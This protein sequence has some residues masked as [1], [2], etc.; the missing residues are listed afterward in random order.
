MLGGS[1]RGII[2]YNTY[3]QTSLEEA[4]QCRK[5]GSEA[6]TALNAANVNNTAGTSVFGVID[7]SRVALQCVP[8]VQGITMVLNV[9]GFNESELGRIRDSISGRFA[10]VKK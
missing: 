6:M 2:V 5:I 9:V 10:S 7:T 4:E 1:G 3:V 8:G